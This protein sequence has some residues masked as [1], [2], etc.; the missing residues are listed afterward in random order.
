M[1]LRLVSDGS[2]TEIE[3]ISKCISN[4][5]S[6]PAGSLPLARGLGI[7]W[8]N[9]SKVPPELEND[10]ATEIISKLSE[11]EPRVS[12]RGVTFGYDD[13]GKVTANIAV[14]RGRIY[15]GR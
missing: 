3:D 5:L 10:I 8:A 11:Y 4:L 1:E 15:G 2:M 7:S 12:V 14:E 9:L 6:V 13:E